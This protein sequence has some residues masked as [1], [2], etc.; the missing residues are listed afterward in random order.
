MQA[1]R[2]FTLIELLVV[3][4]I[5]AVLIALLLPAVQAAREAA[6]RSQ[7][8][9]NM[10]QVGLAMHNYQSTHTT[11]PPPKIYSG[12]CN[13]KNDA[14]GHILNTTGFTLILSYLEQTAL[15]SAYNFSQT[16]ANAF[17]S[18]KANNLF[19]GDERVN[20]TV[21]RSLVSAYACPSDQ[22]PEIKVIS[23]GETGYWTTGARR[24]N[25]VMC[26]T[27]YTEYD[28]PGIT[29]NTPVANSRGMFYTDLATNFSEVKDGLSS[30]CMVGEAT[31]LNHTSNSY[32]PYWGAGAHTSTHGRVL[33][34]SNAQYVGFL[35][36]APWIGDT[37]RRTYAWSMGSTH[38]GGMNMAFGDGSV[39]FIKNSINPQTWWAINTINGGEVVSSD[40]F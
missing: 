25:Y 35:P 5:I 15:S 32:G 12:S 34:V 38:S 29:N 2:G 39:R 16:S 14:D 10:K 1:K 17:Y 28:C 23:T 20:T 21:V 40:A 36:N 6:R 26:A 37:L 8:V 11:L 33:P 7:C 9:N 24:G 4:A 13:T 19:Y 27:I 22:V 31:Q 3:I 30:T 18:G